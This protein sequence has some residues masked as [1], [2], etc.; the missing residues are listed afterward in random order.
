[1]VTRQTA[2]KATG[3]PRRAARPARRPTAAAVL[4]PRL[5]AMRVRLDMAERTARTAGHAATKLARSS[6]REMTTAAMASREA[7]HALWRNVRLA[8]RHIARD[9]MA[10]WHEV[11]PVRTEPLKL[12]VGRRARRPAA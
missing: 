5:A 10:A 1:M 3:T 9:A 6:M 11:V 2:R 8:G 12:P 7:M 4:R